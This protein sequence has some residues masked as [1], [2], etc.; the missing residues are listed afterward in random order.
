MVWSSETG[1][2]ALSLGT[3]QAIRWVTGALA[4][5]MAKWDST[6]IHTRLCLDS[7]RFLIF[8][9]FASGYLL[10]LFQAFYYFIILSFPYMA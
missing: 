10:F 2:V 4:A 6:G 7:C 9:T 1:R 3:I 8:S 5:G